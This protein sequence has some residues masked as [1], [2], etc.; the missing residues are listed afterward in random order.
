MANFYMDRS[1]QDKFHHA[2]G[3][4]DQI[5]TLLLELE[6]QANGRE[7]ICPDILRLPTGALQEAGI[8]LVPMDQFLTDSHAAFLERQAKHENKCKREMNGHKTNNGRSSSILSE[9]QARKAKRAAHDRAL[10]SRMRGKGGG[11]AGKPVTNPNSK[12]ARAKARKEA[13]RRK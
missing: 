10:R 9:S 3:F 7:I 8:E 2:R 13:Q 6:E 1:W 4:P 11:D 5:D 12:R